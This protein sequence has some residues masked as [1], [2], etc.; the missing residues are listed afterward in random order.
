LWVVNTTDEPYTG[1]VSQLVLPAG[2][3]VAGSVAAASTSDNQTFSQEIGDIEPGD[4]VQINWPIE[5]TGGPGTYQFTTQTQFESGQTFSDSHSVTV[6]EGVIF[7][8][9]AYVVDED[10]GAATLTVQRTNASGNE[11]TVEY[12]TSDGTA[13]AGSDYISS[14]GTITFASDE[15]TKTLSISLQDDDLAEE[16]ESIFVRLQNASGGVQTAQQSATTVLIEDD[17]TVSPATFSL[18]LPQTVK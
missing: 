16:E 7:T 1:G 6:H 12:V 14:T 3:T 13:L 17:D 18:F 5:V 11:F 2:L 15:I 10:A 4:A 9:N 8:Q